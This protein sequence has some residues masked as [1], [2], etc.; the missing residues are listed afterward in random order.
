MGLFPLYLIGVAELVRRAQLV[1]YP[2][3]SWLV[4]F[5]RYRGG[6]WVNVS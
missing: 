3:I 6:D 1:V 5:P 2:P 4:G